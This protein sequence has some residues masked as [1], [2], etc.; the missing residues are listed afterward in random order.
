MLISF[1]ET[2]AALRCR[3]NHLIHFVFCELIFENLSMLFDFIAKTSSGFHVCF[4]VVFCFSFALICL[5]GQLPDE[6]LLP[7]TQP[8]PDV[9]RLFILCRSFSYIPFTTSHSRTLH[10]AFSSRLLKFSCRPLARN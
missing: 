4:W 1:V 7:Y 10:D 8:Y 9:M 3:V 2:F 6:I 5:G